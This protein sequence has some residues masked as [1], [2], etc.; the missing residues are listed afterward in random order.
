MP[1][2]GASTQNV[3]SI[4]ELVE[5]IDDIEA[6][7]RR[8]VLWYRGQSNSGWDVKPSIAREYTAEDE[9]NLTNRFY[10]RAAIRMAEAPPYEA[11][12]RW[13]SLMQHYGLPTRLLDWTRSPLIAA[14]FALEPYLV[15]PS[16]LGAS[17]A[18]VW[19]LAPHLLN[20]AQGISPSVTPSI[21]AHMC[22]EL[23]EP[24]FSDKALEPNK[25]I[26]VMASETDLRMFV[27]QGCFTIHSDRTALNKV[28]GNPDFLWRI[29][30]E[31]SQVPTMAHQLGVCGL[32]QGDLFPDLAN[33]A[34]ELRRTHP[35]GWA[36]P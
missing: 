3:S 25:I 24:A 5:A 32:R 1:S 28:H 20:E 31:K 9:R 14:Y 26:A 29:V 7:A 34:Q 6:T 13:L 16:A 11:I 2:P 30:I 21:D 23:L 4:G 22:K 8:Q 36:G 15:D 33:L 35:P 27:Q 10:S 18:T 19:V 17:D 12:S